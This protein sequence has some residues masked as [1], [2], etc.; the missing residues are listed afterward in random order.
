MSYQ[1]DK[2]IH[3]L[4]AEYEKI[5]ENIKNDPLNI[6]EIGIY[7]G[8]SLQWMA[9][10]FPKATILGIDLVIPEILNLNDRITMVTCDQNDSN[11]LRLIGETYGPFDI[12]IDD[13]CHYAKE[14]K[15]AFDNLWR[16]IKPGGYYFIED[17]IAGYWNDPR[18]AGMP[19]L[20]GDIMVR[21]NEL[22]IKDYFIV[23]K[24][25]KCSIA[26]FK[27]I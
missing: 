6:L 10:Y 20:I 17:F 13:G 15:N 11:Q 16:D 26:C 19:G 4:I 7:Q 1:T 21:K 3:G 23:L 2:T 22:K 12:I 18:F 8:G 24:E 5:F 14:T 27:K 25:P 9:E